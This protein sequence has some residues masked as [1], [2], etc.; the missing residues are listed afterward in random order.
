M[1]AETGRGERDL[2]NGRVL[3]RE[4]VDLGKTCVASTGVLAVTV[5]G[6]WVHLPSWQR[7][8]VRE[9]GVALDLAVDAQQQALE[10]EGDDGDGLSIAHPRP[11]PERGTTTRRVSSQRKSPYAKRRP[12]RT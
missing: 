5:T 9:T 12:M 7:L 10:E 1:R 6:C 2:E 3:V 4:D 8:A 11:G